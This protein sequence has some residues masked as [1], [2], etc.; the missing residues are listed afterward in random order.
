MDLPEEFDEADMPVLAAEEIIDEGLLDAEDGATEITESFSLS[1]L[2]SQAQSTYM[3][4][5]TSEVAK[6]KPRKSSAAQFPS[7]GGKV[8]KDKPIPKEKVVSH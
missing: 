4:E 5:K 3:M 8:S 6:S 7:G 2:K 1:R